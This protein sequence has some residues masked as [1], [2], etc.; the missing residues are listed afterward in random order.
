VAT[1]ESIGPLSG[2][3]RTIPS[4]AGAPDSSEVRIDPLHAG[5][6]DLID[7]EFMEYHGNAWRVNGTP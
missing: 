3:R 2:I 5:S 7:R 1:K 6:I 4:K